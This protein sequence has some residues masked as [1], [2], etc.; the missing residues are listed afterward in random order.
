MLLYPNVGL[1]ISEIT[2][3]QGHQI[4]IEAIDL[5]NDWEQ[6][7]SNLLALVEN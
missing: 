4:R 2:E 6:I 7:K 3:L 5:A 1:V